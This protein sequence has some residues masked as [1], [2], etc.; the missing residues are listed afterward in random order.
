MVNP[1]DRLV[2]AFSRLPG[3]GEK[4]A[5][6]LAFFVQR[7][8]RE[9]ANDF[10]EALLSV[11]EELRLCSRCLVPTPRDPCSVCN[12]THREQERICVVEEPADVSAIERTGTYRGLYHILHGVLSPLEGIGPD[13]LK[14]DPLM[15][16]LREGTVTEVILATNSTVDG[17]ATATYLSQLIKPLG[18]QL[19][20][21]ANG[22]PC[23]A[24][25]EY[26]DTQ[27]LTIALADR[28]PM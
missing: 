9:Y 22:M 23:G 2:H 16:R 27:T 1:L 11:K 12:D 10:A 6:R 26:I 18:I 21:L 17:E 5:Q 8:S 3:I 25:V 19:T 7:A 14:I 13:D 20:R 4:S 15:R 28:R 24:E